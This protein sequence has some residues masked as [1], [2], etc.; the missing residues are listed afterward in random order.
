M[1]KEFR[2]AS[3][4]IK[5]RSDKE[6]VE[7][8]IGVPDCLA[9]LLVAPGVAV[10]AKGGTLYQ[11]GVSAKTEKVFARTGGSG[12]KLAATDGVIAAYNKEGRIR[13]LDY[14]G[15][16]LR[17]I[18][19]GEAPI[20]SVAF[21]GG[22]IL[23]A[24]GESC[25]LQIY[26]LSE[27]API[28]EESFAEYVESIASSTQFLA[29]ALSNGDVH[30]YSHSTPNTPNTLNTSN[31]SENHTPNT[32]NTPENLKNLKN[33]KA[34]IVLEKK[35]VLALGRGC[36]VLFLGEDK[37]FIGLVTGVGYIYDVRSG[38]IVNESILHSKGITSA[39][40]FGE[41]LVTASLD[42]KLKV[43]TLGLREISSL[44]L[45]SPI[46]AFSAQ[47]GALEDRAPSTFSPLSLLDTP[48][49]EE[50]ACF[51]SEYL[52]STANG[53]VL[54]YRDR[55]ETK[56]GEVFAAERVR[57][58]STL[59]ARSAATPSLVTE[60]K[61]LGRAAP[62]KRE[63]IEWMVATFQYRRALTEAVSSKDRESLSAVSEYIHQAG[64]LAPILASLPEEAIGE[65]VDMCIDH[66]REKH[67]FPVSRE[68]L[69]VY[70][71]L[72]SGRKGADTSPL[73]A[74][75]DRAIQE[76]DEEYY[77]HSSCAS[78]TEY[79]KLVLQPGKRSYR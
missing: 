31:T 6:I 25:K 55:W 10:Y 53:D 72:L 59:L 44:H 27:A 17:E 18:E 2:L 39:Q 24:G 77:V 52:I 74:H 32:P 28:H 8:Q 7:V 70:G 14:A 49:P 38:H 35:R 57:T 16:R 64:R 37:L 66:V 19:C 5:E 11:V 42:G 75:V 50:K 33:Q 73:F 54:I 21:I 15:N 36:T 65:V 41:F 47:F 23:C 68:V 20:R 46:L 22:S 79:I 3:Y 69:Q 26:D 51:G 61:R 78:L 62:V 34:S 63:T 30:I 13:L 43:S 58:P 12:M 48:K 40:V 71:A 1:E 9:V 45:G 67:Y 56:V 60:K 29:T 4:G 76:L